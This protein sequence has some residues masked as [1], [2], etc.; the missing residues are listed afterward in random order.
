MLAAI[1]QQRGAQVAEDRITPFRKYF[2][3]IQ[4][5]DSLLTR[6][7]NANRGGHR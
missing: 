1:G 6:T 2:E 7:P 3:E 4:P 5:G